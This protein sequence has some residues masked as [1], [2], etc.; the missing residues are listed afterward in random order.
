MQLLPINETGGDNS[1]YNAISSMALDPIT[2]ELTPASLPDLTPEDHASALAEIGMEGLHEGPVQYARVKPLKQ[3][4]L[5]RAFD[6]FNAN[7]SADR[8][9]AFARF[10]ATNAPGSTA[11]RCSGH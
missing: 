10:C 2:L 11:T 9:A 8:R 4:L 6:H 1:P 7:A 3:R 5:R